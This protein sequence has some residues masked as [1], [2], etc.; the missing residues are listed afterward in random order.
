MQLLRQRADHQRQQHLI[1]LR[2][3]LEKGVGEHKKAYA[4][5][6]EK[7]KEKTKARGKTVGDKKKDA[8]QSGIK[9]FATNLGVEKE[10]LKVWSATDQRTKN[11]NRALVAMLARDMQCLSMVDKPGFYNFLGYLQPLYPIPSR[12]AIT[13]LVAEEADQVRQ[14]LREEMDAAPFVSFTTDIWSDTTS[15]LSFISLTGYITHH[16]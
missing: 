4:S 7:E 11:T 6:K 1:S 8:R 16:S 9:E 12:T 14:L 10:K 3:H 13:P 15:K 2:R 5:M